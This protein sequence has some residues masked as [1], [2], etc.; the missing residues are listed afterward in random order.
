VGVLG[1]AVD[2]ELERELR[3]VVDGLGGC[4]IV[5]SSSPLERDGVWAG[6]FSSVAGVGRDDVANAVRSCWASAF[7]PDPLGRLEGCG[8]DLDALELGVLVQPEILPEAGGVARIEAGSGVSV[9]GVLGHPG[10]LLSGWALGARDADLAGLIG[11]QTVADVADLARRVYAELGD[12]VIEWGACD[13]KVWL[14][15]SQRGASPPGAAPATQLP[16]QGT[17]LPAQ[18]A[19]PGTATGPL[20]P[21]R[22]HQTVDC[23]G[24]ILLVDRPLPALAPLLFGARGVISRAAAA[25]SHLAEVARSLGVP[26]V[27]GCHPETVTGPDPAPGA[28]HAAIDGATGEVLLSPATGRRPPRPGALGGGLPVRR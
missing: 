27:T 12:D 23:R 24:A 3:C 7:A 25:G 13:G 9:V 19:A 1:V 26:M 21:C 15:Q 4:V 10:G 16:G 11:S 14:L 20:L 5:R 6:A 28:W 18:P 17:R 2:S 22:P 8:L